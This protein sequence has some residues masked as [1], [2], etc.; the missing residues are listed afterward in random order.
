MLRGYFWSFFL[1][2]YEIFCSGDSIECAPMIDDGTRVGFYF[3]DL[4]PIVLS[5]T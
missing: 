1:L 5:V 2:F 3:N 4:L